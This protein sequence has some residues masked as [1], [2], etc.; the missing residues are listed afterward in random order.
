MA[1]FSS[2]ISVTDLDGTDGFRLDGATP[3]GWTGSGVSGAGDFNGDGIDDLIVGTP[4]QYY[5]PAGEEITQGYAHIVY[6]TA[7]AVSAATSLDDLTPSQGTLVTG[8]DDGDRGGWSV[9]SAGD[10]NGDGVADVIIGAS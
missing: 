5:H 7:G 4:G 10:V 2:V 1:E 6:G 8:F 3:R 9:S